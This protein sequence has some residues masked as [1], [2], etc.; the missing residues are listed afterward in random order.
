MFDNPSPVEFAVSVCHY[1]KGSELP[2]LMGDDKLIYRK[3]GG[4]HAK[5]CL[6]KEMMTHVPKILTICL[7]C[8]NPRH[9]MFSCRNDYSPDDLK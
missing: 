2:A 4:H 6:E 5:D 8:G 3:K 7:K 1:A 9:D